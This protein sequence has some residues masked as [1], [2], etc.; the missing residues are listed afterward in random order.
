MRGL[1]CN[2]PNIKAFVERWTACYIGKIV[3]SPENALQ[4]QF[5]RAKISQPRKNG[6][7][8]RS[9]NNNNFT[10][11][12]KKMLGKLSLKSGFKLQ[13]TNCNGTKLLKS[14]SKGAKPLKKKILA[15][16]AESALVKVL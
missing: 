1:F 5:F 4:K 16:I 12:L 3:K 10:N 14:T 13:K 11:I 7:Q 15:E 6:Q 8:Q 9:C 2:I